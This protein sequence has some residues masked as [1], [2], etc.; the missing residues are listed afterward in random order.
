MSMGWLK[1]LQASTEKSGGDVYIRDKRNRRV[2]HPE[3]GGWKHK[4]LS[5]LKDEFFDQNDPRKSNLEFFVGLR[6]RIEHRYEKNIAAMVAGRTQAYLLNYE[7]TLVEVFGE[8]EALGSEIR[9]PLFLSSITG[10]AVEAIKKTRRQ[11]PKGTL[12]WVQDFDASID[13]DVV[14]DQKFDFRIYL[15]PHKGA[16]SEADAAMTFV[17]AEDLTEEQNLLVDQVQTIIHEKQ[18]HVAALGTLLPGKV[19]MKVAERLGRRFTQHN[20]T[21]AWN[22]FEVR[23]AGDSGNPAKTK[24]DF[25]LYNAP[26]GSYVYTE[27]WVDYLVRKL[28][29]E[30]IYQE[31]IS[32]KL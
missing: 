31:V 5:T 8:D 29:D 16:K 7:N 21:Q 19:A 22:Y 2:R 17:R 3:D 6:N 24:Q 15:I 28:S 30:S 4:P 18:V 20:H 14:S 26:F 9:F 27:A 13:P 1:L 10:G 32:L 11:I 25:C 12:E 23:P